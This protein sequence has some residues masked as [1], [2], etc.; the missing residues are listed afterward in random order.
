M[1]QTSA[2]FC[3]LCR[4]KN[5]CA[6]SANGSIDECWCQTACFP[7]KAAVKELTDGSSCICQDCLSRIKQELALGLKRV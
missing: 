3:P 6:V 4:N 1:T 5:L 7:P 2:T